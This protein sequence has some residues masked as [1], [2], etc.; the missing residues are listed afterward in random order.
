[1]L[2]KLKGFIKISQFSIDQA[3]YGNFLDN[4]TAWLSSTTTTTTDR[5]RHLI[6]SF[7]RVHICAR[8]HIRTSPDNKY[9][10]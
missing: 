6:L 7:L 10:R 9:G 5:R 1:M 3:T 2:Q 4:V 8:Q